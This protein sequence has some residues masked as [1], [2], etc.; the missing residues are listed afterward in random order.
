MAVQSTAMAGPLCNAVLR[1][2]T[3][4]LTKVSGGP[5]CPWPLA[6]KNHD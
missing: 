3:F 5:G 1:E 4:M 2:N 6:L